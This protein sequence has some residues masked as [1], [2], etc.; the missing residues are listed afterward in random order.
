MDFGAPKA[1]VGINIA[2]AAQKALIEQERFDPGAAGSRLLYK[3]VNANFERVGAEG[4][5]LFREGLRG[6][7][8][9]TAET[10]RVGVAQLAIIVEQEKGVSM[11]SVRL[12]HG[13]WRDLSSHSEVHEQRGWSGITVCGG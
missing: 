7:V 4:L 3:F 5:Q 10:A 6:Q 2:D 9:E 8:S 12:R 13:I 11:L 1:L